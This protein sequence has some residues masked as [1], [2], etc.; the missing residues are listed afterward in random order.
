MAKDMTEADIFSSLE[1]EMTRAFQSSQRDTTENWRRGQKEEDLENRKLSYTSE[2]LLKFYSPYLRPPRGFNFFDK[3]TSKTPLL[4]LA[5]MPSPLTQESNF[6]ESEFHGRGRGRGGGGRGRGAERERDR[7]RG[8]QKSEYGW[9]RDEEKQSGR[10]RGGATSATAAAPPWKK[11]LEAKAAAEEAA[12]A[13]S[14]EEKPKTWA[15][16]REARLERERQQ[17]K[18]ESQAKE[19]APVEPTPEPKA[20]PAATP[21]AQPA[22]VQPSQ[23]SVPVDQRKWFYLDPNM[24]ERGPFPGASMEKWLERKFF[25]IDLQV[26]TAEFPTFGS[27]AMVFFKEQRNPFSGVPILQWMSQ[28]KNCKEFEQDLWQFLNEQIQRQMQQHPAAQQQGP[29]FGA[30]QAGGHPSAGPIFGP[31]SGGHGNQQPGFAPVTGPIFGPPAGQSAGPMFG[32][33]QS[34]GPM[35]SN[36][37]PASGPIFGPTTGAPHSGPMFGPTTSQQHPIFGPSSGITQQPPSFHQQGPIFG[38]TTGNPQ[39]GQFHPGP[40]QAAAPPNPSQQ[41]PIFGPVSGGNPSQFPSA[42]PI[43]GPPQ[44]QQPGWN[45]THTAQPTQEPAQLASPAKQPVPKDIPEPEPHSSAKP[46]Q[47]QKK[48]QPKNQKQPQEKPEPKEDPNKAHWGN[49]QPQQTKKPNMQEIQKQERLKAEKGSGLPGTSPPRQ[50][51]LLKSLWENSFGGPTPPPSTK[52]EQ[53]HVQKSPLAKSQEIPPKA[54]W[55]SPDKHSAPTI[56][57]IQEETLKLQ[58]YQRELQNEQDRKNQEAQQKKAAAP[59][60]GGGNAKAQGFSLLDIQSEQAKSR[61][62]QQHHQPQAHQS[63]PST[64]GA[65]IKDRGSGM[66]FSELQEQERLASRAKMHGGKGTQD[67]E[68]LKERMQREQFIIQ[69]GGGQ[70]RAAPQPAPAVHSHTP[71]FS[72]LQ[73]E[74]ARAKGRGGKGGQ[75]PQQYKGNKPAAKGAWGASGGTH[76]PSFQELQQEAARAKGGK[77]GRGQPQAQSHAQEEDDN[78]GFFDYGN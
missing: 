38:P 51:D 71:S 2:E 16:E 32:P 10:G 11:N 39:G 31:T 76:T 65:P 49:Q 15:S 55:G 73:A 78:I 29:I 18:K 62:K 64:W 4:P 14:A 66:S 1:P 17:R 43:F 50:E 33:T 28:P 25:K 30:K 22:P 77:G 70:P 21:V 60:W 41:H 40:T 8:F 12:E 20:Q 68:Q 61:P 42:G 7:D 48:N 26:R 13:A 37:S 44:G 47:Q 59:V 57:M 63:H 27:L 24:Q 52:V 74:E 3:V 75:P 35:F 72:E 46:S 69:Q 56:Q 45:A 53:P 58:A 9:G 19:S 54:G 34:Q 36:Q 5:R 23:A 6:I 67:D